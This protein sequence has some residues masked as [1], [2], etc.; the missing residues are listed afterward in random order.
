MMM[1]PP[2]A[3]QRAFRGLALRDE[4][5]TSDLADLRRNNFSTSFLLVD[6]TIGFKADHDHDDANTSCVQRWRRHLAKDDP[7]SRS[8]IHC[9]QESTINNFPL[10]SLHF[11]RVILL[12]LGTYFGT[13]IVLFRGRFRLG[14]RHLAPP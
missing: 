14:C 1:I 3:C 8:S 2:N 4:T 10:P 7:L 9:Q 13:S 12:L 6:K 5:C 11:S